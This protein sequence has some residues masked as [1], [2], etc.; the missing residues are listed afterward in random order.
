VTEETD[1]AEIWESIWEQAVPSTAAM[2]TISTQYLTFNSNQKDLCNCFAKF[3][4][5]VQFEQNHQLSRSAKSGA[6]S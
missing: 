3:V 5:C 4:G 6:F 2:L 1:L